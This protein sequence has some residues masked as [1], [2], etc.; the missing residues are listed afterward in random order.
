MKNRNVSE[1]KMCSVNEEPKKLD[2]FTLSEKA[3][4][5]TQGLR[6][7]YTEDWRVNLHDPN[8]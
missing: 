5:L 8:K 2:L 7:G 1:F 3:S 4:N 6:G